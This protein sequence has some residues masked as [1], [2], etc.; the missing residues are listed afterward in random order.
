MPRFDDEFDP[1]DSYDSFVD[2]L[3]REPILDDDDELVG[4]LDPEDLALLAPPRRK[5]VAPPPRK[6]R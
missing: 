2:G 1:N 6:K 3:D 4:D 5:P